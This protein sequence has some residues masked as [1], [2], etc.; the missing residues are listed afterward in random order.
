L[1]RLPIQSA[2]LPIETLQLPLLCLKL[3]A[4]PGT[5][6]LLDDL[7]PLGLQRAQGGR[8]FPRHSLL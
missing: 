4:V 5:L 2:L 3:L 7:E 1:S 8:E 6:L